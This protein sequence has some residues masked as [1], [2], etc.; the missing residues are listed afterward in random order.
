MSFNLPQSTIDFLRDGRQLD[1]DP[2]Q[3]EAGRV[4]LKQLDQLTLEEVQVDPEELNSNPHEGEFGY[5]AVP[6]VS[7]SGD[8]ASYNPVFILLWLPE[9]KFFGAWDCDHL[10]LTVFPNTAWEDIVANPL[11]Y[12]NAQWYPDNDIGIPFQPWP[13]YEFRLFQK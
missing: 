5:Y 2:T 6:A 3:C 10:V 11:P 4:G 13:K 8:C 12:L 9:E 7:L 1:Y